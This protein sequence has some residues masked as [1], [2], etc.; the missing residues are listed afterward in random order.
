[1]ATLAEVIAIGAEA[2]R[3]RAARAA[4]V[5]VSLAGLASGTA[6]SYLILLYGFAF[7]VR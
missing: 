5:L 1:M 6:V 4:A 3:R 2:K 7:L